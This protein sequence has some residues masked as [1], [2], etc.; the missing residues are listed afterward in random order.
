MESSNSSFHEYEYEYEYEYAP[1]HKRIAAVRHGDYFVCPRGPLMP[2]I[3]IPWTDSAAI[4]AHRESCEFCIKGR[5]ESAQERQLQN[6]GA[7]RLEG[8]LDVIRNLKPDVDFPDRLRAE[9]DEKKKE[10]GQEI[11]Y[12]EQQRLK[13][14]EYDSGVSR[15]KIEKERVELYKLLN[16]ENEVIRQGAKEAYLRYINAMKKLKREEEVVTPIN[17]SSLKPSLGTLT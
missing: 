5:Q 9:F 10:S 8:I 1:G 7:Q 15:S 13:N 4:R 16:H 12:I 3:Q 11:S 14:A 17:P 2:S 6:E